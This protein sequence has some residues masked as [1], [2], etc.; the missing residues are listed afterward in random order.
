MLGDDGEMLV[1]ETA[2]THPQP[3]PHGVHHLLGRDRAV[4]GQGSPNGQVWGEVRILE[5]REA[6]EEMPDC[7]GVEGELPGRGD[8]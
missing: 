5:S 4:P 3:C 7:Q 2:H 1:I 8:I 6:P